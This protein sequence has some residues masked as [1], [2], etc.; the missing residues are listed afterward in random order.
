MPKKSKRKQQL[1]AELVG[2]AYFEKSDK[3]NILCASLWAIARGTQWELDAK[4][5]INGCYPKFFTLDQRKY[6]YN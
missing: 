6:Q 3:V 5:I 1:V 2:D 4:D